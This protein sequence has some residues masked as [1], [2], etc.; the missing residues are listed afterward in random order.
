M[1]GADGE[2]WVDVGAAAA[3][4]EGGRL[5]VEVDGYFVAVVQLEDGLHAFEDRCSHDGE[6][7]AGA[8]LEADASTPCGVVICPRHG[9]RFC[10]RTGEALTPPAYEPLQIFAVRRR[11]D[12]IEV[13]RP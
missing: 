12:R 3:L 6:S 2:H 8:D 10:L 7:L 4:A 11:D 5:D 13:A 9:A 1:T